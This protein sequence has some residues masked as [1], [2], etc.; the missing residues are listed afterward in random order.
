MIGPS[1]PFCDHLHATKYRSEGEDYMGYALRA[2]A[3]LADNDMHRQMLL[4]MFAEMRGLPAGRVQS[5]AGATKK[6]TPYNCFVSPTIH[7][8]F[9]DGPNPLRGDDPRSVS[10][11][12]AAMFSAQTMRMG[13]GVG[14][15]FSTL[16]PSGDNIAG[17]QATTDGPI[18]F[19]PVFDAVCKATSSAGHRRG[20]QMGTLRCDH[21]DIEKFITMKTNNTFLT[22][23][24]VSVLVTDE[25]M[26]AVARN[27]SF[28]LR[29]GGRKYK[30]VDARELWHLIMKS[31]HEWAEPGVLFIDTINR[32][33]NLYYCETISATNPCGEQ[34]LPP[35]GACLL[36]SLNLVKYV[37]TD[38]S[39]QRYFNWDL[40]KDDIA[41]F[42]RAL[43]NVIDKATYPTPQQE[44]EA[45]NKRRMGAGVTGLANAL[46]AL[47]HE[48]GS[49][50]FLTMESKITS[51][52]RDESYR[53]SIQLAREKGSFP[54]F[55]K[56][57]YLKSAFVMTLP[58]DIRDGI[59][60]YG[61]RNSHLTSIAPT[62]TISFC[63]DNVSSSI[64]PV[65][66]LEQ[67]RPVKMPGGEQIV[68]VQD[69]GYRFF[70]VKGK[71]TARVTVDE[72]VAVL[73]TA[74]NRVDSA[75]SKTVNVD[76]HV[77]WKDFVGIYQRVYEGGGKGCTTF[78]KDGKKW[79]L[80]KDKDE[81]Q[82]AGPVVGE[83]EVKEIKTCEWDP[84]TGRKSCE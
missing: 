59:A 68:N 72:H 69:Y 28:D 52:L 21:P 75:V 27:S 25:L 66:S 37:E 64:E 11:M 74:A 38:A 24:N 73:L 50:G 30:T 65:F 57:M 41:H 42:I 48:Y 82:T 4:E 78:N 34:P 33:N 49:I 45:K 40:F 19:M 5:W 17:V 79:A 9:V 3:A 23:F 43:D 8:S 39:G 35:W 26:E 56:D 63:A 71:T 51:V 83:P 70:G 36:G 31:T 20:A 44:A 67:E 55:D 15:D 54:L 77:P 1:L 84:E 60:R 29:F 80:L 6:V 62:G 22:G 46:E 7:D 14:Y 76:K 58:E 18:A 10:I 16:R 2:S 47:G 13:G 32:M 53:T 12:H 61:I 81:D